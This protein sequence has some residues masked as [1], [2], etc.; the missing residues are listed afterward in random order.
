MLKKYFAFVVGIIVFTVYL[1]TLSPSISGGDS[2]ELAAVQATLGIAHPTGYPLFTIIG[3]LFSLLP[4][5][6]TTIYKLNL[7]SAIFATGGIIV[8]YLISKLLLDNFS[9]KLELKRDDKNQ[10]LFGFKLTEDFKITASAFGSFLLAFSSI[11]WY[12]STSVEVY[13]LHLLLLNL[14]IYYILRAYLAKVDKHDSF[15]MK[16]K[17][18]I[19]VSIFLALGFTNHLTTVYLVPGII[20]LFFIKN[21]FTVQ[22]IKV[23]A[24]MILL[25]LIIAGIIYLYIPFRA[26]QDP[27]LNWGNPNTIEKMIY[28]ITGGQFHGHLFNNWDTPKYQS[29]Y[30]IWTLF[31]SDLWQFNLGIFISLI[32]FIPL[33][34]YQRKLLIF[35]SLLLFTNIIISINY[36]IPDI[37]AYFLL[38]YVILSL[39]AVI[40]LVTIKGLIKSRIIANSAIAFLFIAIIGGQLYTS[41]SEVDRSDNFMYADYTGELLKRLEKNAVIVTNQNGPFYFPSLY[42]QK[43]DNIRPDVAVICLSFQTDWYLEQ[44]KKTNPD[45]IDTVNNKFKF[46]L[47]ERPLYIYSQ[48]FDQFNFPSGYQTVPDLFLFKVVKTDKYVPADFPNFKIRIPKNHSDPEVKFLIDNI[49]SMLENRA[50]Y[51][52][53]FDN[54]EKA[55]IYTS[56]IIYE[57]PEFNISDD[58]QHIVK[59]LTQTK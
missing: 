29:V 36:L 13:S 39:I 46:D 37:N 22:S 43:V 30:F 23:G 6:F 31:R 58:L 32:G 47:D 21:K 9:E 50:K 40:G 11:Y 24:L 12:Q 52:L 28:H 4:I 19:L 35:F 44:I 56:K 38:S 8:F 17:P 25:F 45:L 53:Q 55:K 27:A 20:Y 33:Y 51:E 16:Y 59:D 3:Y 14:N 1:Y 34:F 42:L 15:V 2:S 48:I 54:Y 18:W 10:L 7:L 5:S 57:F 41:F 49:G 26:S